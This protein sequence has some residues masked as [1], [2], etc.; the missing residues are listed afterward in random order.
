MI[1]VGTGSV[2]AMD[3]GKALA[4]KVSKQEARYRN[5][6]NGEQRCFVCKHYFIGH[7]SIVSGRVSAWGWCRFFEPNA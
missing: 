7:C 6:P 4:A 2:A 5:R 3:A 1:V